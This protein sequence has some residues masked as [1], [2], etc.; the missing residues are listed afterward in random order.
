M[1]MAENLMNMLLMSCWVSGVNEDVIKVDDDR[2]VHEI[3]EDAICV[4]Q[5]A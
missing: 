3:G 5:P 1:E 2:D 4:T